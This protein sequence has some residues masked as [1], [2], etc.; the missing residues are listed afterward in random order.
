MSPGHA[1][2]RADASPA[3][4]TG[5]V[6]RCRTLGGALV[7]RG[8]TASLVTRA[9]PEGLGSS[10][11]AAGLSVVAIPADLPPASEPAH[12][13]SVLGDHR[14]TLIVADHYGVGAEW[15]DG[16]RDL[17]RVTMAIDDLGDRAQPA[18]VLLNQNLG[19]DV[20][21]LASLIPA[22]ARLLTGPRY[23]L[24]DP[25]FAALRANGRTA[26]RGLDGG[27]RRVMV[28]I[29]GADPNDVTGR[30]VD[31]L[32]GLDIGVD[33]VVGA[34]YSD[35]DSLRARVE[36]LQ[37][38][39]LHVN[40]STMPAITDQADLAIGAPSSASWERCTLGLATVLIALA[41]NQL[42][43]ER[44]L[45]DAG[46]ALTA[47]WHSSVTSASIRA[48]VV[49]LMAEPARVAAMARAAAAVTDGRGTQ[50]VVE[51]IEVM[52]AARTEA[53]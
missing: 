1:I 35:V 14:A 31:A 17:A 21:R 16:V 22:E 34:A 18:D 7:A 6:V 24:V 51:E 12:L 36:R 47:G 25:A 53:G 28:F 42:G 33:V 43:V 41:D 11:R 26:S 37:A 5:H 45:V 39:R 20:G 19:S 50:R 15:F 2:L 4:G 30:A 46:A 52:V 9:L 13:R 23:A 10:V 38:G 27:I 40:V 49:E 44:A 8:W 29:S 3:I 32:I 48:I